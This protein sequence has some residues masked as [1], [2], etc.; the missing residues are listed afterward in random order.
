MLALA[1]WS[2]CV[3]WLAWRASAHTPLRGWLLAGALLYLGVFLFP[4]QAHE[5]YAFAAVPLLA[6]SAATSSGKSTKV[7]WQQ[8]A[9]YG[10]ITIDHMLNLIWAAP[11]SPTVE[12]AFAGRTGA[13]VA[14]AVLICGTM[15]GGWYLLKYES[16]GAYPLRAEGNV[17][18]RVNHPGH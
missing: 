8:A 5:R 18:A 2:A 16:K 4:T 6:A 10:M 7:V 13:G 3:L 11:F 9:L 15:I 12:A 17:D 14:I 1:I